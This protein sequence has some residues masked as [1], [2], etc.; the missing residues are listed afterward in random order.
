MYCI[1][2]YA[3]V[4]YIVYSIWYTIYTEASL[5]LQLLMVR[6]QTNRPSLAGYCKQ[7]TVYSVHFSLYRLQ[8]TMYCI[9]FSSVYNLYCTQYTVHCTLYMGGSISGRD[10]ASA[11]DGEIG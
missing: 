2:V 4:D 3:M 5:S 10:P 6:R 1:L 11:P 8:F 9:H 7:C